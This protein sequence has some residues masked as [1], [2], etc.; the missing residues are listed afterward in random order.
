MSRRPLNLA[1]KHVRRLVQAEH[2]TGLSDG[3]LLE[4][5]CARRDESAFAELMARHGPM[6]LGVCRRVLH[7]AHHAEDALQ[8]TFLLLCRHAKA[9]RKGDSVG[10]WL[11]GAAYRIALA[12]RRER[13]RRRAREQSAA[14]TTAPEPLADLSWREVRSVIDTELA[15]LPE[16]LRAPLV[17]CYLEGQTRDEAAA[18]LGWSLSTFRGRLE[19]GRAVLQRRL[20]ARGLGLSAALLATLVG[21]STSSALA[22]AVVGATAQAAAGLAAGRAVVGLVSPAVAGLFHG[23]IKAMFVTRLTY[24]V[25]SLAVA[26]T[27]AGVGVFGFHRVAAEGDGPPAKSAPIPTGGGKELTIEELKRKADL[28]R[29]ALESF[30]FRVTLVPPKDFKP[31]IELFTVELHVADRREPHGIGP[32]G[33]PVAADALISVEQAASLIDMIQRTGGFPPLQLGVIRK[34]SPHTSVI[35]SYNEPNSDKPIVLG[36]ALDWELAMVQR[37]EA[38]RAY[39]G[40][41]PGRIFDEFLKPLRAWL[42][43][44]PVEKKRLTEIEKLRGV[45][46]AERLQEW[47]DRR[48]G[49]ARQVYD[50]WRFTD[51][52]VTFV[53]ND[54][55]APTTSIYTLAPDREPKA[56]DLKALGTIQMCGIYE[57]NGD[58]LRVCVVEKGRDADGRLPD[59]P[60]DFDSHDGNL[61]GHFMLFELKRAHV[62]GEG[63]MS[64]TGF[65]NLG[66]VQAQKELPPPGLMKVELRGKL[67]LH[68]M[69]EAYQM[70]VRDPDNSR[71]FTTNETSGWG[72]MKA[73]LVPDKNKELEELLNHLVGQEVL[74]S[75]YLKAEPGKAGGIRLTIQITHA[76][77]VRRIDPLGILPSS[78][79]LDTQIHWQRAVGP[80]E[81]RMS[82]FPGGCPGVAKVCSADLAKANV[83]TARETPEDATPKPKPRELSDAQV[84]SIR[85]LIRRLP[86]SAESPNLMTAILVSVR[87]DKGNVQTYLYDRRNVPVEIRRL[88]DL[89]GAY[90]EQEG[91]KAKD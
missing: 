47:G 63:N 55:K 73:E 23:A 35:V 78:A 87:D 6:V 12:L 90:L 36:L 34:D 18:S 42:E 40:G 52:H 8:A 58:R 41:E 29:A 15:R 69:S 26:A 1:L 24:A 86:P 50:M 11:H 32:N 17:L 71:V 39:L 60:R 25:A 67:L 82:W 57:I 53:V 13:K 76:D 4:R 21:E 43:A 68:G 56:I 75:G 70:E 91:G 38:L 22:P 10:S 33:K 28:Q 14:P 89:T 64:L 65:V 59:R 3:Q 61:L 46:K 88:Y 79:A 16:H 20:S 9:V 7:D 54:G 83:L 85:K 80:N 49:L 48:G 37:L 66:T 27:L 31:P 44:N 77:Q 84:D 30:S 19:R 72:P 81:V 74:V 62:L 51:D 45:W 5:F 2:F